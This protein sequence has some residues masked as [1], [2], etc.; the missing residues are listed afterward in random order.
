MASLTQPDTAGQAEPVTRAPVRDL[1]PAQLKF[2]LDLSQP[3][4]NPENEWLMPRRTQPTAS[5]MMRRGFVKDHGRGIGCAE[6]LYSLTD[7]G[8]EHL[9]ILMRQP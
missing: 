8:R 3:N 2:L 7:S 5:A 6:R 4:G 9:R 1:S